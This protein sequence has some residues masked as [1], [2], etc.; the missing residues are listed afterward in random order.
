MSNYKH[1]EELSAEH[2]HAIFR[3]TDGV[4]KNV[5]FKYG[6]VSFGEG[7]DECNCNFQFTIVSEGHEQYQF[8]DTFVKLMSEILQAVMEEIFV[9]EA[10]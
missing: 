3:I 9:D 2:K 5:C 8:E 7:K 1:D 10:N 6:A 4:Y